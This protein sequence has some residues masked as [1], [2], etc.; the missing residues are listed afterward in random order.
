VHGSDG[1]L[2]EFALSTFLTFLGASG[3]GLAGALV[4]DY[5]GVLGAREDTGPGELVLA[6]VVFV[7]AGG[8]FWTG[9]RIQARG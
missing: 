2:V 8:L 4:L 6:A 5:F 7:V 3:F 9:R 1:W